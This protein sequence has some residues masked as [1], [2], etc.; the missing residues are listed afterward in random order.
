MEE[1]SLRMTDSSAV[2]GIEGVAEWIGETAFERWKQIVEFIESNYPHVFDIDWIYGGKKHGWTLRYKKSRS[3]CTLIPEKNRLCVLIVFGR[4]ER[5]KTETILSELTEQVQRDY[6]SATTYHDGKWLVVD[7]D[8]DE[9][10]S[11]IR[12]LLTIKRK[13]K[14]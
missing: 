8:S 2:P 7:A 14:I 13:P 6:E 4:A 11:D 9:A 10:I 12:R 5:E 3:F 1:Q